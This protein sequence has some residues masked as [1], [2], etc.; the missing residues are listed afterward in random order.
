MGGNK[1]ILIEK[2]TKIYVLA[3]ANTFTGGPELLH[4]IA[5]NIK[6]IFKVKTTMIYLPTSSDHPVHKNFKNIT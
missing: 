2:K 1:K 3:P 4:Q 6:K 5:F